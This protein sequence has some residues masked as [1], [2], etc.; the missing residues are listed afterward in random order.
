MEWITLARL[1][2][3]TIRL[4]SHFKIRNLLWRRESAHPSSCW[5]ESKSIKHWFLSLGWQRKRCFWIRI[6]SQTSTFHR[7]QFEMIN[8]T[9]LIAFLIWAICLLN[10]SISSSSISRRLEIGF[11][12]LHFLEHSVAAGSFLPNHLSA[13]HESRC[14]SRKL[15]K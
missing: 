10:Y 3:L 4:W 2:R 11:Q 13:A 7:S 14:W 5:G 12:F 15:S 8:F 6:H 9:I 1:S